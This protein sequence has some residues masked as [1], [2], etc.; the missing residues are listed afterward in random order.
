MVRPMAK[1]VAVIIAGCGAK[2]GTEIHEA[3][4]TLLHLA[5]R[6]AHVTCY[7][8]A[9]P[10]AHV[11]N[12]LSGE[13]SSN[14]KRSMAAEAARI[15]RGAVSDLATLSANSA[16]ALILPGGFGA[17][18]NLCNF[19]A[20]G[21]HCSVHPEVQRVVESFFSARRPIG[22]ICIAPVIAAKVL[23]RH[24]VK[25]TIGND[26]ETAKKIT[27]MGAVHVPTP[28]GQ[29]C[30]DRAHKIVSTPAYMLAQ[31]IAEVDQG[32]AALV[33]EVL[34]LIEA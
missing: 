2:D 26:T 29:A 13:A 9:G 4:L 20:E 33:E 30:V 24:G 27:A 10:Q 1:H 23:G 28:V 19:A 3:T 16:D 34:A 32:I 14:E 17:A 31:S 7:S 12:H 18:S 22:F 5:K 6:G 15:A 11:I 25:L 8:P 21:E